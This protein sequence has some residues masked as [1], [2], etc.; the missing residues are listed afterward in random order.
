[1]SRP[2]R[3]ANYRGGSGRSAVLF[4]LVTLA[5]VLAVLAACG[6]SGDSGVEEDRRFATDPEPAPTELPSTSTSVPTLV[7]VTPTATAASA[8][9]VATPLP[10]TSQVRHIYSL[11]DGR[12]VVV[13]VETGDS[14]TI[15]E[16]LGARTIVRAVAKPDGSAVAV[17]RQS[18]DEH[19]VFDVDVIDAAGTSLGGWTDLESTLGVGS[20]NQRGALAADWDA[21]GERLAVVF[22]DGGGVVARPGGTIVL[23]VSRGQ[24][25]APIE[26]AWSPDDE[27]VA[28]TSRDLDDDSP[29]LAIGSARVLPIDPVRIAGTGGSRPIQ[30]IVWQ[31]DGD[32]LLAIQGMSVMNEA[33]G[34]DLIQVDRRSLNVTFAVGGSR[35]GPGERIVAVVASPDG[36]SWG[37]VTVAPGAPGRLKATA[38][39]A[40]GAMSNVV[41]LDLG[42]DPPIAGL[43]WTALGISVTL[44]EG[45]T[46]RVA[47]FEPDGSPTG[48]PVLVASPE[49]QASPAD[50]ALPILNASTPVATPDR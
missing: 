29:Y 47:S 26:I 31:P 3:H 21:E 11:I 13:D 9:P 48:I 23:L 24:A 10:P 1:M 43:N 15:A 20:G 34:G 5:L 40:A 49:A 14:K 30:G 27:A 16:S 37:Y 36:V 28:F 44:F 39:G 12:V 2:D 46:V 18:A 4:R 32:R 7:P 45:D 42:D 50:G 25:P 6:D 41:R 17:F 33:V 8:S 35:F 38:W 19:P 22:P